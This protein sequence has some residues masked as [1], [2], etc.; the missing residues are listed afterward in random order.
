MN[1][2]LEEIFEQTPVTTDADGHLLIGKLNA[3]GVIQLRRLHVTDLSAMTGPPGPTGPTGAAGAPGVTGATGP[4]G[5][6]GATGPT[7]GTGAAGPTGANGPT[8]PTGPTGASGATGA[9]G[10][11]GTAGANGASETVDSFALEDFQAYGDGAISSFSS[12]SGWSGTGAASGA[13]I[14]SVTMFDGRTD[15][16]LSLAG[17]GE[18]KRKMI[19]GENWKRLRIGLLLRIAG[20]ATITN[21]FVFG[22]CS[23]ITNGAGSATCANFIGAG[24]RPLSSNQYTFAAGSD[25]GVYSATFAGAS[26]KRVN[27]FTDYGGSS[28]MKGYPAAGSTALCANILDIKRGRLAASATYGM[29][30]QGPTGA[31]TAA[32]SAEQFLDWGGLLKIVGDPDVATYNLNW[33]WDGNASTQSATFDESAGALDSVNIWWSHATTAVE[34][35]GIA[36]FKL[37]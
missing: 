31:G 29:F 6:A 26:S 8:G 3:G 21:D 27:T 11:T 35:A 24:T 36:V 7:G 23:G 13:S 15:K 5:P 28:S 10:P 16:R 18:F 34:I 32:G 25:V 17:P 12:G 20:G 22:V 1:I 14:V 37:Y 30:V 9:T 33:W 19:W 2:P 4:T